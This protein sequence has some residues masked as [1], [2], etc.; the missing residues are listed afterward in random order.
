LPPRFAGGH[1]CAQIFVDMQLEMAFHL[2]GEILLA[3]VPAE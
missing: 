3:P 1:A 2:R